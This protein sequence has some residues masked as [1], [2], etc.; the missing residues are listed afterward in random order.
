MNKKRTVL[1]IDDDDDDRTIFSAAIK[2][3]HSDIQC[4]TA[5][6]G[7]DALM[8]L[9]NEATQ[10]PDFI[11]LDLNM[12]CMNGKQ[13]LAEIKNNSRLL[14]IPIIMY[15]TTKRHEDMEDVKKLGASFFITKPA[16]FDEICAAITFV[17][18]KNWGENTPLSQ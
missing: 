6:S 3:I 7:H 15:S 8:L 18:E 13:C 14:H 9:K 12:P 4:I 16:L 1:I 11:F 2:E 5:K 10:L 17:L